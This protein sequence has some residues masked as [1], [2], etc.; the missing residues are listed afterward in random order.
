M[1]HKKEKMTFRRRVRRQIL[2]KVFTQFIHNALLMEKM[3]S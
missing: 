2:K 3:G 1:A